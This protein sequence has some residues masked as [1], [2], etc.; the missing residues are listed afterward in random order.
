MLAEEESPK[1][2]MLNFVMPL[3]GSNLRK[4]ELK[5]IVI[6]SSADYMEKEWASLANFPGIWFF[7][8][9]VDYSVYP[10]NVA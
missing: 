10:M 4:S 6:V 7:P 5:D 8:V 9:S 2:G 1:L 3:R